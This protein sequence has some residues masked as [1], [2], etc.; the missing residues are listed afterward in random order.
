[1]SILEDTEEKLKNRDHNVQM[2]KERIQALGYMMD[3][4]LTEENTGPDHVGEDIYYL[5]GSNNSRIIFKAWGLDPEVRVEIRDN[6]NTEW[7]EVLRMDAGAFATAPMMLDIASDVSNEMRELAM[8]MTGTV[9][10]KDGAWYDMELPAT[11]QD[12]QKFALITEDRLYNLTLDM[13]SGRKGRLRFRERWSLD[14]ADTDAVKNFHFSDIVKADIAYEAKL[15][16]ER[17]KMRREFE[18]R[19]RRG[20]VSQWVHDQVRKIRNHFGGGGPKPKP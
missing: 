2:A 14:L 3:I 7:Q 19:A 18:E 11:V 10:N 20:P 1:M 16:A 8:K 12:Q 5:V 17:E 15:E 6:I 4:R 13:R 9:K